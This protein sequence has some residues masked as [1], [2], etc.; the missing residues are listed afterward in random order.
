ML[1]MI[2]ARRER[3]RAAEAAAARENAGVEGSQQPAEDEGLAALQRNLDSL[4]RD[5]Q[6][7]GIFQILNKSSLSAEYAFNGWRPDTRRRW[8]EVIEVHAAPGEDIDLAIVRSMIALIRSHYTGDFLWES[9]RLGRVVP[10]SARPEDNAALENFLV[11]EF[12]G[13]PVLKPSNR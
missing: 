6:T 10:L 4:S 1:A 2:N 3:R 13:T 11:R 5:D 8:R 12:F 9:R 7:G